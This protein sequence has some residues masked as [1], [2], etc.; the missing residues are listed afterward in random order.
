MTL[1]AVRVA[2]QAL[3]CL[4]ERT[5]RD[6]RGGRCSQHSGDHQNRAH[7]QSRAAQQRRLPGHLSR[8]PVHRSKLCQHV[9][10]Y[11]TGEVS[12][13]NSGLQRIGPAAAQPKQD[14]ESEAEVNN[15]GGGPMCLISAAEDVLSWSMPVGMCL[16][17]VATA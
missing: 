3:V 11:G 17:L 8:E 10:A 6:L 5:R 2:V 4:R 9:R 1:D 14:G 15:K 7:E 12:D 13:L 16:W